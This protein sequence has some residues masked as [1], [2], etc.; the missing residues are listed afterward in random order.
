MLSQ[1]EPGMIDWRNEFLSDFNII[2]E[3]TIRIQME[4]KATLLAKPHDKNPS[5][6]PR[7]LTCAPFFAIFLQLIWKFFGRFVLSHFDYHFPDER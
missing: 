2:R 5:Q 1:N 6:C 4:I 3:L 7:W